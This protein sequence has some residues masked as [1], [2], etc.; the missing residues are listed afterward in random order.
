MKVQVTITNYVDVDL[1][2]GD[3]VF[4]LRNAKDEIRTNMGVI[5]KM[6]ETPS[7]VYAVFTNGTWRPVSTYNETWWKVE[8]V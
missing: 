6:V 8:Y 2:P 3:K 7:G 1:K 4:F 5:S